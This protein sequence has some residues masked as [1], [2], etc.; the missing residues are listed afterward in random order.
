MEILVA[1]GR[2]HVVKTGFNDFTR[3]FW[4]IYDRHVALPGYKGLDKLQLLSWR[5]DKYIHLM[6]YG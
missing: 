5:V 2:A 3:N 4:L 1:L 6:Y